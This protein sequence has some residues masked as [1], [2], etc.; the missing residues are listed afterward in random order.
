MLFKNWPE[1]FI[2]YTE[3]Y[4]RGLKFFIVD[5]TLPTEILTMVN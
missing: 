3:S 1:N 2:T 5:S 4:I